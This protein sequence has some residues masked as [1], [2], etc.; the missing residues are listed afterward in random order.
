[1][2][3]VRLLS[4]RIISVI[5]RINR[6]FII[7]FLL[8]W[9]AYRNPSRGLPLPPKSTTECSH[10]TY[11]FKFLKRILLFFF[12]FQKHLFRAN[13]R[14]LRCRNNE[15]AFFLISKRSAA[16]HSITLPAEAFA[17][18]EQKPRVTAVSITFCAYRVY[19]NNNNDNGI[20]NQ[21]NGRV[22]AHSIISPTSN[23]FP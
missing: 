21:Q 14:R 16:H 4:P 18:C 2:V 17:F 22:Q 8:T 20:K 6:Y 7:F 10:A 23:R 1:M 11:V 13:P 19:D 15:R 9:Q 5:F 3:F 12:F